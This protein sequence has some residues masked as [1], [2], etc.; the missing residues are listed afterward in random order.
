MVPI[1]LN[2]IDDNAFKPERV[3]DID[4][5][6]VPSSTNTLKLSEGVPVESAFNLVNDHIRV[7]IVD[8]D[9]APVN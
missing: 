3:L 1:T 2:L 9:K 6:V 8:N 7:H 5:D 4:I